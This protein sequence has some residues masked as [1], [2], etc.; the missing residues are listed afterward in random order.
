MPYNWVK[1]IFSFRV[2]WNL[3]RIDTLNLSN[4]HT[5]FRHHTVPR[6]RAA[7]PQS[8]E[9]SAKGVPQGNFVIGSKIKSVLKPPH[10]VANFMLVSYLKTVLR[11]RPWFSYSELICK[12][13]FW[14]KKTD[15]KST[16][17]NS[18]HLVISYAVFCL[19]KK[20]GKTC[21]NV[22]RTHHIPTIVYTQLHPSAQRHKTHSSSR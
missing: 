13:H 3:W 7:L 10:I 19:K 18:S 6:C 16:R 12:G 22:L 15:R 21:I 9:N 1:K 8:F 20:R 14:A 11:C 4:Q 5:K 17:L 2:I